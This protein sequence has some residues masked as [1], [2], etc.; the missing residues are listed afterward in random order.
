MVLRILRV[1]R[2]EADAV[3]ALPDENVRSLVEQSPRADAWLALLG[4][5]SFLQSESGKAFLMYGQKG[6]SLISMGDPVGDPNEWEDLLWDFREMADARSLR[7]VFYQVSADRLNL[8][9]EMGLQVVKLGENGR[10]PLE[11]FSLDGPRAKHWR[12]SLSRGERDGLTFRIVDPPLDEGLVD[13]LKVI[14]DQWMQSKNAREKAFSLGCFRHDYVRSMPAALV[15]KEGQTLAFANLWASG[16][17]E[18][19]SPDLMRYCDDAPGGV[20]EFLFLKTMLW[21]KEQGFRWF[22][23]GMAPLSGL[24]NRQ[25]APLWNRVGTL[26]FRHGETFYNFQGLRGYKE[27]FSPVW[28]PRYLAYPGRYAL[29]KS[30]VDIAALIAGDIK[31]VFGR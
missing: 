15:E 6:G 13:G 11:Q 3:S 17:K 21:A 27:K 31:G 9:I 2:P 23:L 25:L 8:Y 30:M 26:V 12:H 4:D 29:G 19:I 14:S 16:V 22:D 28:E 20:M 18:E 24:E 7:S 5:K 10:V 1:V